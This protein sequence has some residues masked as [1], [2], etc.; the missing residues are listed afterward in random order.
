MYI[1]FRCWASAFFNP[2]LLS[3]SFCLQ[4]KFGA[5]LIT[6]KL[7]IRLHAH[8][9]QIRNIFFLPQ[10]VVFAKIRTLEYKMIHPWHATLLEQV[11]YINTNTTP[12]LTMLFHG[13]HFIQWYPP[14]YSMMSPS[15]YPCD[16]ASAG[17]GPIMYGPRTW[18]FNILWA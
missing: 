11:Q 7:Q 6:R 13:C 1:L 3:I 8:M 17:T 10:N 15:D 14:M 9:F 5:L 18:K 12:V 4:F 2:I 16:E